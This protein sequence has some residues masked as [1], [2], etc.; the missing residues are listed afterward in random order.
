M[1]KLIKQE[2]R[3]V[4]VVGDIHGDYDKFMRLLDKLEYD[5]DADLLILLG[6]IID[7]GPDSYKTLKFVLENDIPCLRG[8]HEDMW[9]TGQHAAWM[10]NGGSWVLDAMGD[11]EADFWRGE[12]EKL[13]LVIE[14]KT[15]KEKTLA[16]V[17]AELPMEKPLAKIKEM[18]EGPPNQK[19][20]R[21]E[22]TLLW[23]RSLRRDRAVY[24]YADLVLCGHTVVEDPTMLG[25]RL[26]LDTG[27]VFHNNLSAYVLEPNE[28]KGKVIQCP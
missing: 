14:L 12:L 20:S 5:K 25:N 17:H 18:L 21:L 22:H 11:K 16:L 8:N 15:D 28:E 2:D 19:R 9:V 10:Y 3:R 27:A 24:P 4:I 23:G 26:Y 7:R 6:D 13:P 1:Y